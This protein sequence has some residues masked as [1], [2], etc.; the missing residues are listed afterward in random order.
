MSVAASLS[1]STQGR[2][3]LGA[4]SG[5]LPTIDPH[6]TRPAQSGTQGWRWAGSLGKGS[7]LATGDRSSKRMSL[8]PRCIIISLALMTEV[9]RQ[10]SGWNRWAPEAPKIGGRHPVHGLTM[11]RVA[12]PLRPHW[13]QFIALRPR[14]LYIHPAYASVGSPGARDTGSRGAHTAP[15]GG[16]GREFGGSEHAT[17]RCADYSR[18]LARPSRRGGPGVA[19]LPPS[20]RSPGK[21]TYAPLSSALT[22]IELRSLKRARSKGGGDVPAS[23]VHR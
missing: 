22:P 8:G 10:G 1:A 18:T 2:A 9:Q 23:R 6:T 12:G 19:A 13:A 3:R 4:S 21:M 7:G 20:R 11:L 5:P 14:A 17:R 16:R 15:V